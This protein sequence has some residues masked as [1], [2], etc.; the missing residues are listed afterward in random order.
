MPKKSKQTGRTAGQEQAPQAR[1][2]PSL[3]EVLYSSSFSY[4]PSLED[5]AARLLGP[6]H[7]EAALN[8]CGGLI[9]ALIVVMLTFD[10]GLLPLAI[11]GVV[12]FVAVMAVSN[13]LVRIK[14]RWLDSH[15]H[16]AAAL[17]EEA[18]R[19]CV[20]VT[21]T[22]VIVEAAGAEPVAYPLSELRRARH[23]EDLCLADFGRG[24]LALFPRKAFGLAAYTSICK[25]L[26]EG[27]AQG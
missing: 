10:R 19:R 20:S 11:A 9:C 27:P 1:V 22:H 12:L 24:R 5:D 21:S 15:G 8:V 17:D 6:E 18:S 4:T 14:R 23:T 16:N 7:A 2:D 3:G 13:R 25:L 26:S